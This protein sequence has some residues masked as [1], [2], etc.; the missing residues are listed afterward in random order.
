MDELEA[1]TKIAELEKL[2]KDAKSNSNYWSEKHTELSREVE[3]LHQLI[4]LLP[5]SPPRESEPPEDEKWKTVTYS[6]QSRLTAWIATR[7][8]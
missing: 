5:N 3:Q 8:K 1:M 6:V 4:D 7:L 2:A